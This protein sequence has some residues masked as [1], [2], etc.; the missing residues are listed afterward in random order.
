MIYPTVM[1]YI[2]CFLSGDVD[3]FQWPFSCLLNCVLT[4]AP[5]QLSFL[6]SAPIPKCYFQ[7]MFFYS[8]KLLFKYVV[9]LGLIN[10]QP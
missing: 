10:W 1:M 4:L 7:N 2:T 9:F 3:I 8:H 5:A 6:I